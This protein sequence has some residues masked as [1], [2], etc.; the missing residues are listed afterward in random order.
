[1]VMHYLRRPV[2]TGAHKLFALFLVGA[3]LGA[4][5]AV[6]PQVLL[7]SPGAPQQSAQIPHEAITSRYVL[8]YVGSSQCAPSNARYLPGAVQRLQ[9]RIEIEAAA[10]G[11]AFSAVGVAIDGDTRDGIRHLERTADFDEIQVGQG[12]R[13]LALQEFVYAHPLGSPAT[14]Q[15]ILVRQE[16]EGGSARILSFTL[17]DRRVGSQALRD[18]AAKEQS[19]V[20]EASR[21]TVTGP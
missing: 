9:N 12:W 1:M 3:M 14:P 6:G 20:A 17:V 21:D 7:G 13:D 15:M 18:W 5:W 19:L 16:T 4:A 10:R 11:L 2:N 8:I